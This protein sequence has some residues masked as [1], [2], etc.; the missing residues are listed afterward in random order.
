MT[1]PTVPKIPYGGDYKPEQWPEKVWD[2]DHWL[3][4]AAH[5]D[6]VTL[7]RVGRARSRIRQPA[8]VSV[9]PAAR[10]GG[11]C[12]VYRDTRRGRFDRNGWGRR[13]AGRGVGP[14]EVHG[15][16]PAL[17]TRGSLRGG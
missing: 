15:R 1:P 12:G 17:W 6:T 14:G 7:G 5:I 3:F 2:E 16:A 11:S 13:E 10:S 4:D 9:N 8:Q